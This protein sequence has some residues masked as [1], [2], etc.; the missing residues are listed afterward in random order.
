MLLI[1]L[2]GFFEQINCQCQ[3]NPN[4]NFFRV[5]IQLLGFN[6]TEYN[7]YLQQTPQTQSPLFCS[8]FTQNSCC[9]QEFEQSLTQMA[10][11]YQT[12]LLDSLSYLD[13]QIT[14]FENNLKQ[15]GLNT[16][17]SFSNSGI[18]NKLY[19]D[20]DTIINKISYLKTGFFRGSLC[21]MCSTFDNTLYIDQATN[22]TI[23]NAL[24]QQYK[25]QLVGNYTDLQSL[26]ETAKSYLLR[27]YTL[28]SD[29]YNC[30]QYMQEFIS[31]NVALCPGNDCETF[32]IQ[33]SQLFEL[34]GISRILSE[35]DYFIQTTGL[36]I[37]KP[38][39]NSLSMI[40][41]LQVIEIM[42]Y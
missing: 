29:T 36:D 22:K 40:L 25:S 33:T 37:F 30:S 4:L 2:L 34:D 15:C 31:S 13:A 6:G 9:T 19:K 41:L 17:I 1:V 20:Y 23:V 27:Y 10:I 38:I 11:K 39:L 3:N 42:I 35:N 5:A 32:I 12:Q 16:N 14:N 18:G 21:I 8:Q 7:K 28:Y 26:M 24:Y